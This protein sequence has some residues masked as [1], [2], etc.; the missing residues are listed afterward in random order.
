MRKAMTAM[1]GAVHAAVHREEWGRPESP[2][3]EY[4]EAGEYVM[5]EPAEPDEP[6]AVEIDGQWWTR[7]QS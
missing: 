3:G 5:Y 4:D 7:R 6:G 2:S 1:G